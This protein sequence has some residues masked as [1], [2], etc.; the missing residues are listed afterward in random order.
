ML[1]FQPRV[2]GPASAALI[3]NTIWG[4]AGFSTALVVLHVAAVPLG[5]WPAY[6]LSLATSMAWNFTVWSLRRRAATRAR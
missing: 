5:V 2:G 6:V 3:A 1:I 4:L